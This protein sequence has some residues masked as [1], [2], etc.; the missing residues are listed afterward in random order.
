MGTRAP[1]H[2]IICGRTTPSHVTPS[3]PP[4]KKH[5]ARAAG[6]DAVAALGTVVADEQRGRRGGRN[7]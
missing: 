7:R 3:V 5:R 4:L 6:A 1:P 2:A